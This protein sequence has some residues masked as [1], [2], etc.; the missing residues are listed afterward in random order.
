MPWGVLS[1][2]L[3]RGLCVQLEEIKASSDL[4]GAVGRAVRGGAMPNLRRLIQSVMGG[5]EDSGRQLRPLCTALGAG[6]VPLLEELRLEG[7]HV[8]PSLPSLA[9]ALMARDKVACQPLRRLEVF[10]GAAGE[11]LGRIL[12]TRCCERLEA[13]GLFG[14]S[15]SRHRGLEGKRSMD[16]VAEYFASGRAKALR[17]LNMAGGEGMDMARL[18]QF[19]QPNA[20]ALRQLNLD[21]KE[22]GDAHVAHLVRMDELQHLK[23]SWTH[24]AGHAGELLGAVMEGHRFVHTAS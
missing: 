3:Q 20:P 22:L 19:L 13:L 10:V 16:V 8:E 17:L 21:T 4:V 12:N 9:D 15:I 24:A 2:A 14:E 7:W 11:H 23:G 1:E 18:L 6:E 5:D